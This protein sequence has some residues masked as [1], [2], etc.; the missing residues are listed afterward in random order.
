M[1][2]GG[3][4]SFLFSGKRSAAYVLLREFR[5]DDRKVSDFLVLDR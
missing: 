3:E 4:N 1:V 5:E 2:V